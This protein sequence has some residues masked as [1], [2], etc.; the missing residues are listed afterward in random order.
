MPT[1]SV[2]NIDT[3]TENEEIPQSPHFCQ[4]VS[5]RNTTENSKA[6]NTLLTQVCY[7][8]KLFPFVTYHLA[9]EL[10]PPN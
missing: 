6:N 10:S 9:T 4:I 1:P 3:D 5:E 2:S 8:T 7:Y